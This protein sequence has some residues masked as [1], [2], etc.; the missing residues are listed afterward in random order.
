MKH[1]RTLIAVAL[2]TVLSLG[3]VVAYRGDVLMKGPNAMSADECE[4]MLDEYDAWTTHS[5]GRMAQLLT[6][7]QFGRF[8]EAKR[9]GDQETYAALRVELGLNDGAGLR[10]GSGY[11]RDG[12]QYRNAGNGARDGA[13][14]KHRGGQGMQARSAQ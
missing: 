11:A 13:G 7:E 1:M 4:N 2:I 12:K 10:D 9:T 14:F 8:V 3:M 6:K 5:Q